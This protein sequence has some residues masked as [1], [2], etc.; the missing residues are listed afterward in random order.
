MC[1]ESCSIVYGGIIEK[2]EKERNIGGIRVGLGFE[3]WR[4]QTTLC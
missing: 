1:N 3:V 4:M 2:V